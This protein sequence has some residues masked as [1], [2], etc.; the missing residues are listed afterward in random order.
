MFSDR[1]VI[2]DVS[3]A[4]FGLTQ[5]IPHRAVYVYTRFGYTKN[6]L[7]GL[8]SP[9]YLQGYIPTDSQLDLYIESKFI[10]LLFLLNQYKLQV[11]MPTDNRGAPKR[12]L[13]KSTRAMA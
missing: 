10:G 11:T 12:S 9:D 6:A 4:E 5:P 1:S 7:T 8:L 3:G 13:L 2:H